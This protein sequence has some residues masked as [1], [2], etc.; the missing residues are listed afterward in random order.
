MCHFEINTILFLDHETARCLSLQVQP[1]IALVDDIIKVNVSAAKQHQPVT[2]LAELEER[3]QHFWSFGH[4]V[5]DGA[6]CLDLDTG[7]CQGGT[8][9]GIEPMGLLWSMVPKHKPGIRLGKRDITTPY[10]IQLHLLD[11][12]KSMDE[13]KNISANDKHMNCILDSV[14]LERWYI[15]KDVQRIPVNDGCI[16]GMLFLPSGPGPF[17]GVI[18]LFGTFGGLT[19]FRAALLASR[20]IA[21]LALA[22]FQYEDLPK[23][24][25]DVQLDYFETAANWLS[26]HNSVIDGGVGVLGVSKG[27]NLALLMAEHFKQ[28]KAV[29][30]INACHFLSET[31]I[32]YRGQ[33]LPGFMPDMEHIEFSDEGIKL[34]KTYELAEVPEECIIKVEKSDAK[35]LLLFGEDDCNLR[36]PPS[37][38]AHT[39]NFSIV[40]VCGEAACMSTVSHKRTLGREFSTSSILRLPED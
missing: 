3:G 6:G 7:V 38:G 40:H 37:V 34:S 36:I 25:A 2:L 35:Y 4:Y 27:G 24:L 15:R 31:P 1:A 28:I 12:H 16:R 23:T 33:T 30:A 20:G 9:K 18:D 39:T 8:Y 5:T 17:P 26:S 13:L 21:S 11:G 10:H 32:T 22:F 29:C 19:E 14:N